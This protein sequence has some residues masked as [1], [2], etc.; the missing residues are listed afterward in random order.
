[1]A[2]SRAALAAIAALSIAL[3]GCGGA[4]APATKTGAAEPPAWP[5]ATAAPGGWSAVRVAGGAVLYHPPGWSAEGGDAGTA[6]EI[7]PGPSG[8]IAGYLNVT[9][10][11]GRETP[12]DWAAFRVDHNRGEG[13]RD[14]V[15]EGSAAGLRF[16]SGTGSCVRDAYTTSLRVRYVEIACLVGSPHGSFVIV[17]AAPCSGWA[18]ERGVLLR[19]LSAFVA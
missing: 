10:R 5:A 7:L 13:E 18:S 19:A 16:A 1:M 6:T 11:Q 14:V 15:G 9:P 4:G 3:T 8:A 2:T 12:A 17:A